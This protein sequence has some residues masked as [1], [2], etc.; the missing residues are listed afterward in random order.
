[1]LQLKP[2]IAAL[3]D[4][5]TVTGHERRAFDCVKTLCG[6]HFDEVTSDAVG[7]LYLIRRCGKDGAPCLMLDAHLDEVG[8]I[9]TGIKDGGFLTVAPVGGLDTRVLIAESVTVYGREGEFSGVVVSTPPHLQKPGDAKKLPAVTELLIDVGYPKDV[10]ERIAP[11]GTPIGYNPGTFE[12]QNHQLVGKG[13][14]D[15]ACAAIL[16]CAVAN[17]PRPTDCDVCVTLSTREEVGGAGAIIAAYRLNPLASIVFD[18]NFARTPDTDKLKTIELG[19]GPSISISMVTHRGLTRALIDYAESHD[20]KLQQISEVRY[21]GTNADGMPKVRS[22]IAV[23]VISL[24]LKN[25]HTQSEILSLDDA[26]EAEKL[27]SGFA[28][29]GFGEFLEKYTSGVRF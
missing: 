2:T 18:V 6:D 17:M 9:V 15:K 19:G 24:P 29:E 27:F 23:A 4:V 25:M 12:L 16:L 10:L 11:I 13:F 22:G 21:T 7:S 28:T 8:M 20:L 3:S 1:M 26:A 5:M 14:D